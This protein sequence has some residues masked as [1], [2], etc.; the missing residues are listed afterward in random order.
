MLDLYLSLFPIVSAFPSR[1]VKL[2]LTFVPRRLRS[3]TEGI[4][5]HDKCSTKRSSLVM[6]AANSHHALHNSP[7][8][9]SMG[10]GSKIPNR[11]MWALNLTKIVWLPWGGETWALSLSWIKQ[12]AVSKH[13]G[14]TEGYFSRWLWEVNSKLPLQYREIPGWVWGASS[15]QL[16]AGHVEEETAATFVHKGSASWSIQ[17]GRCFPNSIQ[18][19]MIF[20]VVSVSEEQGAIQ[21]NYMD[22]QET[23]R[24]G[25]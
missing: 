16:Q 18:E 20:Y 7:L 3:V 12:W 21:I 13:S 6:L 14:S 11:S 8:G 25:A 10:C 24:V 23:G 15:H 22:E 1:E 4:R 9:I 2:V 17:N 19:N 5:K